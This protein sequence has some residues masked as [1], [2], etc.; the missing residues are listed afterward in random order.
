MNHGHARLSAPIFMMLLNFFFPVPFQVIVLISGGIGITPMQSIYNQFVLENA[1]GRY[2][3]KV[4]VY[5]Y[6]FMLVLRHV[7]LF[8]FPVVTDFI[9]PYRSYLSGPSRTRRCRIISTRTARS[10]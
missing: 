3:R 9:A 4:R 1:A 6:I 10:I 7:L 2:F 5:V 8:I